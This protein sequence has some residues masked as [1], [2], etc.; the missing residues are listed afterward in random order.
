VSRWVWYCV[1]IL[2]P[3]ACSLLLTP[4]VSPDCRFCPLLPLNSTKIL[5]TLA[6]IGKPPGVPNFP[7]LAYHGYLRT[8]AIGSR[9]ASSLGGLELIYPSG[10][11]VPHLGQQ[12]RYECFPRLLQRR[13]ARDRPAVGV[14]GFLSERN[15]RAGQ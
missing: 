4:R 3:P 12:R 7:Y 15:G 11:Q 1:A 13:C 6:H 5:Q 2:K 10:G 8:T 9:S 14:D